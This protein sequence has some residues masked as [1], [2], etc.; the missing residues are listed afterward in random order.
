[1]IMPHLCLVQ[2][3]HLP[4]NNFFSS[5][6]FWFFRILF[7]CSVHKNFFFS[8]SSASSLNIIIY[9]VYAYNEIC[10]QSVCWGARVRVRAHPSLGHPFSIKWKIS[11][12][13][14]FSAM[15]MLMMLHDD[16][17]DDV[18]FLN[19]SRKG[20][21]YKSSY[22]FAVLS[23]WFIHSVLISLSPPLKDRGDMRSIID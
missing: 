2:Q 8:S 23:S 7:K 15:M 17:N 16:D 4:F 1:M 18:N 19:R 20:A 9:M 21:S 3:Y 12:P 5:S 13:Y 22:P 11:N 14:F 6:L 10:I